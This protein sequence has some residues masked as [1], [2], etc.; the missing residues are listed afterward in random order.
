[1]VGAAQGARTGRGDGLAL[2]RRLLI[3]TAIAL[4]AVAIA[5]AIG[6]IADYKQRRDDLADLD[7]L[8]SLRGGPV[9]YLGDE[10]DGLP[11]TRADM[12]A[13]GDVAVFDYGTCDPGP[14]SGCGTPIQ[15]QNFR[16]AN[17]RTGVAIF[18]DS[19]RAP[20][21]RAALRPVNRP[22]RRSKPM[23]SLGGNT[24]AAGC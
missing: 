14:E 22:A 8:R 24:F 19:D 17:G 20:R 3:I 9:F 21:V 10:F 6:L 13:G 23:V 7:E 5:A 1:M 12:R 2:T 18:A 16:C 4:A 15:L 11:L